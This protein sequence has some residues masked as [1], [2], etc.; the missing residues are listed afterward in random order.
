MAFY[1]VFHVGAVDHVNIFVGLKKGDNYMGDGE[2][3]QSPSVKNFNI[4]LS[5]F[6]FT[7]SDASSNGDATLYLKNRLID[8]LS[9]H[10]SDI[11]HPS[12]GDDYGV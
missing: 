1:F 7:L 9:Q 2:E 3:S 12:K 8:R 11:V 10:S 5:C 6:S 4:D